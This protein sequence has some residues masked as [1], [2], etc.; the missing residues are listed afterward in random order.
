MA[1]NKIIQERNINEIIHFTT[2]VGLVG[3]FSQN[4][5]LP[6][7][8]LKDES[9]LA[10]IFQQNS[11]TRKEK[12][13][14]WLKYCNL[15]ITK[16]NH[17]FFSYSKYRWREQ[18]MFWAILS[19]SPDILTHDDVFFTTTNNIYPSCI[20]GKGVESLELMFSDSIEGKFQ[21]TFTRTPTHQKS[22]TTCE[23]AEILYPNKLDIKYIQKIYVENDLEKFSVCA[24]LYSMNK[25]IEVIVKPEIFNNLGQQPCVKK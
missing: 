7:S 6:N 15:S 1:I 21:K 25:K 4:G 20:R 13:K 12:N 3:I 8:E 11:E 10:F 24:Q 9:T 23:Q 5:I 22:W 2:N 17:E 14:N 19:I 18:D 16:P